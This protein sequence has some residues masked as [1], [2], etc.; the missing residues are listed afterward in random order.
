MSC[1]DISRNFSIGH[2]FF[3]KKQCRLYKNQDENEK[4]VQLSL[5]S[6]KRTITQF[7]YTAWPD[8]G[9]PE[10]LGLVQFHKA[11]TKKYQLGGLMLVHC[12][13]VIQYV[14]IMTDY[15]FEKKKTGKSKGNK[16]IKPNNFYF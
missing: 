7:H 12:R 6:E 9:T 4:K 15:L 10:E 2:R 16:T 13:S 3:L 14:Q 8:H 11:V 5:Q 1:N